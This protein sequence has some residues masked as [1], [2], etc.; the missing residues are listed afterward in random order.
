M[1]SRED[2]ELF[3]SF[4]ARFWDT[5]GGQSARRP[6]W[7]EDG[8][9]YFGGGRRQHVFVSATLFP[10]WG[11]W[12]KQ[13][14]LAKDASCMRLDAFTGAFV[15]SGDSYPLS[16]SPPYLL[17][18]DEKRYGDFYSVWVSVSCPSKAE[19]ERRLADA[20]ARVKGLR[21]A[22]LNIEPLPVLPY[23]S[24]WCQE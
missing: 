20:E 23:P 3:H 22:T 9:E 24:A 15:K 6:F 14:D 10:T 11:D 21:T 16:D 18:K 13:A 7:Y 12:K 5:H 19:F 2:F 1:I 4:N 8:N 17:E